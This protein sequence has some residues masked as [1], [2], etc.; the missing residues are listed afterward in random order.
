MRVQIISEKGGAAAAFRLDRLQSLTVKKLDPGDFLAVEVLR[1]PFCSHDIVLGNIG[2]LSYDGARY[3]LLLP[4]KRNAEVRCAHCNRINH[5]LESA[6]EPFAVE[7]RP[8][9]RDSFEA[10]V[11]Q[12]VNQPPP[13]T[14]SERAGCLGLLLF[15]FLHR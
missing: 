5:V 2:D 15:P 12:F 8:L 9:K 14:V 13:Q 6:A 3:R 11:D 4:Q 7:F 10:Q 1:C